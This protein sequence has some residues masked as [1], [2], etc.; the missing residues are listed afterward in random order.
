MATPSPITVPVNIVM[1]DPA[2]LT[3]DQQIR[4]RT[5]EALTVYYQD[6]TIYASAL[7]PQQLIQKAQ[8][9]ESYIKGND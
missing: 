7:S 6:K 1:N 3:A 8:T 9:I 2:P 5:M 4:M